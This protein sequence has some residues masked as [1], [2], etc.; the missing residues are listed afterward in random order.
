ML[1]TQGEYGGPKQ[2]WIRDAINETVSLFGSLE[3]ALP[4]AMLKETWN[5][6]L[7]VKLTFE[8]LH[9]YPEVFFS[10]E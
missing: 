8:A 4:H 5:G 3:A 6:A 2:E 7:F 10:F 1:D 9:S